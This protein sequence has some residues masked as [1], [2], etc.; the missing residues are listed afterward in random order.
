MNVKRMAAAVLVCAAVFAV[1]LHP[2]RPARAADCPGDGTVR[3]GL[4]PGEDTQTMLGV[5]KP[6]SEELGRRLGCPVELIVATSYSAGIEAMRAKKLD[7]STFG[8]LSYVLA[9]K[10]ANAEALVVQGRAD[11]TSVSYEATIVAPKPT[12]ITKL[13]DVAG[14]TFAY[15]DP[16]STSGHLMPAYALRKVG[17]DPDTGVQPFFAGSHT[18]S[19]EA[20]RNH[21]VE[22]GELN[23]SLI[24]VATAAGIYDPAAYVTLWHSGPLAA[25]PT[26]IRGDLP[27]AFKKRVLAAFLAMDLRTIPDAKHV[28]AGTRY[29]RAKDA[30]YN[31]IRDMVSTLHI[32]L[33]HINE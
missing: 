4:I 22:A 26:S 23:S 16:A 18:A 32:D 6:I 8:P 13:R 31:T 10:V 25:S 20:L 29:V 7:I 5:Y 30:D 19:F 17:I 12:A 21:K 3:F 14:H 9:H 15:S 33:E 28:I 27:P 2:A 11:G 1:A 24:R